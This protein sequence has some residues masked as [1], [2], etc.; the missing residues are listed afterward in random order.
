MSLHFEL[1]VSRWHQVFFAAASAAFTIFDPKAVFRQNSSAK[2]GDGSTL[3][4]G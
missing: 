2:T 4:K 3:S 1:A